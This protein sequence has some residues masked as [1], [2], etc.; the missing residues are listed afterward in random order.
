MLLHICANSPL[1]KEMLCFQV[2]IHT[3]RFLSEIVCITGLDASGYP[4]VLP[5]Y[6]YPTCH[7]IETFP[8]RQGMLIYIFFKNSYLVFVYVYILLHEFTCTVC[9][10][11]QVPAK[12]RSGQLIPEKLYSGKNYCESPDVGTGNLTWMISVEA[13]STINHWAYSPGPWTCI[14]M[15]CWPLTSVV[16]RMEQMWKWANTKPEFY[17][18]HCISSYSLLLLPWKYA[19]PKLLGLGRDRK[20]VLQVYIGQWSPRKHKHYNILIVA[21]PRNLSC[22][23]ELLFTDTCDSYSFE[24]KTVS[25]FRLHFLRILHYQLWTHT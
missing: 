5:A 15:L 17:K 14:I 8:K 10:Q 22:L 13:P 7:M 16:N 4:H 12:V 9:V 24:T 20:Y 1:R 6:N 21:W 23:A 18:A 3:C 2:Y 25:K 11:V 19:L